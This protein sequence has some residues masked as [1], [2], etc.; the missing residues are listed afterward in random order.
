MFCTTHDNL[1]LY[2]EIKGDVF[3]TETIV[4]LNGLTQST[5]SWGLLLPYFEKRYRIVL[6]DFIFQ[7]QSDKSGAWRDFDQHARD[8]KC[9]L[10]KEGIEVTAL[11]GISYG[12][13]VA[14][15]FTLLFPAMV[16]RLVLLSTF[17]S[18][19]PY[20][21]AIELAWRRALESGGYNLLLDVMLPSVLSEEYFAN[22]LIPI[23]V[24]KEMRKDINS[25]AEPILKLM[26]AT[27]ERRNYLKEIG[28][29]RCPTLIIHG[30]KDLLIP[31]HLAREVH[32]HIPGSKLIVIPNAGH[33]LN[34]EHVGEVGK[35]LTEFR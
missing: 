5:Q 34:L 19:T 17:A 28:S 25:D 16:K 26:R 2:Y 9:V 31:V 10:D 20:L 35:L 7:G 21:E 22:P 14:Q 24:M 23:D 11:A 8:V 13:L 15:H 18:K 30:E 32:R 12:S 3:A 29:I 6:L 4:F 27:S 33:T 1:K